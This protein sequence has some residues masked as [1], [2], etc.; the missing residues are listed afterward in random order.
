MP[1]NTERQTYQVR[2]NRDTDTHANHTC[3]LFSGISRD[4]VAISNSCHCAQ[5][6]IQC[7]NVRVVVISNEQ[8]RIGNPVRL[9]HVVS[10]HTIA[11]ETWLKSCCIASNVKLATPELVVA[12]QFQ[13]SDETVPKEWQKGAH[14]HSL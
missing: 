1:V 9:A 5:C 3:D 10:L 8:P 6:P 13:N 4:D 2:E 11:D 14:T 12:F 7:C